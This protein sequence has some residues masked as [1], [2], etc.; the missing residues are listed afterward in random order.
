VTR[1]LAKREDARATGRANEAAA[2]AAAGAAAVAAEVWY[3][4]A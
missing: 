3:A 2:A 1:G 4:R